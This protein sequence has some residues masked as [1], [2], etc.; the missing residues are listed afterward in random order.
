MEVRFASEDALGPHL[1]QLRDDAYGDLVD[2]LGLDIQADRTKDPV[3]FFWSGDALFEELIED[4]PFLAAAADHAQ[5]GEGT[6]HPVT[7]H[8]GIVLVPQ[9]LGKEIGLHPLTVIV[10]L[11]IFAKLLGFLGL[12]L[13]VPLAA[14]S[15]ILGKEFILPLILEFA[16]EKP[17]PPPEAST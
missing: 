3:E 9:I 7:Q 6:V 4:Q 12:L 2:A 15:K 14:I 10:T 17:D 8:E 13:S 16:E 11:L 1:D 5:E